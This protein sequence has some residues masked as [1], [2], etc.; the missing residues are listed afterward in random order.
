MSVIPIITKTTKF[1]AKKNQGI[2]TQLVALLI[3]YQ[4]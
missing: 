4:T 1:E 3:S 2:F